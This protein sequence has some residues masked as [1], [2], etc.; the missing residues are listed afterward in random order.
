M[1]FHSALNPG[2]LSTKSD[3]NITF[4]LQLK[5]GSGREVPQYFCPNIS[6]W[7]HQHS[8]PPHQFSSYSIC[9]CKKFRWILLPITFRCHSYKSLKC[10][11]SDLMT[12][13][14]AHVYLDSPQD[15][16]PTLCTQTLRWVERLNLIVIYWSYLLTQ[17][18]CREWDLEFRQTEGENL[19]QIE[20]INN[21]IM[22][23]SAE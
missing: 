15:I 14:P 11:R 12:T 10:V 5:M 2:K 3:W 8:S 17:Y 4:K 1:A 18:K 16:L 19:L 21:S 13:S 6:T 23:P 22:S 9:T 20:N 7:S